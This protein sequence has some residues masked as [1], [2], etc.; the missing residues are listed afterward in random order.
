MAS[1]IKTA[2]GS[3]AQAITCT[4][5]S[6][7]DGSAR[8]SAAVD[9]TVNEW[10]DALVMLQIKTGAANGSDKRIYL[11]AYATVDAATPVY[12]DAVS[13]ADAAITMNSPT[14]LRLLGVIEAS[15]AST[16]FIGGPW[17]IAQVFGS[18]PKKWGIVV[19]NKSG[20]ALDATEG[21]HKKIYQGVYSTVG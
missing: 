7:A 9:N 10:L 8:Q 1:A 16:A 15:A 12:P 4:L 3:E 14:Q 11:W 21:N 6:L 2:Y 19:Q 13:G 17:S 20:A 5:A 18:M